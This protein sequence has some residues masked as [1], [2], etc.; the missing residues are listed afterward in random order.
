MLQPA[1]KAIYPRL[2]LHPG[3]VAQERRV[4]FRTLGGGEAEY[5]ERNKRE[6]YF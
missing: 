1:M 2:T 6:D 5:M 4:R 3:E